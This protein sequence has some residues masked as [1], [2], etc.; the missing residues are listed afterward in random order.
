VMH[1]GLSCLC[2]LVGHLLQPL[3]FWGH[4]WV[5]AQTVFDDG[6]ADPD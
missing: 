4:R 2:F 5:D 6:A 3:L 1:F